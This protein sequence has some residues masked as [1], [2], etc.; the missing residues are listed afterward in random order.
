MTIL[1]KTAGVVAAPAKQTKK[2]A[3]FCCYC[4]AKGLAESVFTSH[5]VKTE[6]GPKGTICC[7]ELL[8]N[9]CGYCHALGH[10]PKFCPKL[11]ARDE[12]R[13]KAA[14]RLPKAISSFAMKQS[15]FPSLPS[16]IAKDSE[17]PAEIAAAHDAWVGNGLIP[18]AIQA[19]GEAFFENIDRTTSIVEEMQGIDAQT[20]EVESFRMRQALQQQNAALKVAFAPQRCFDALENELCRANAQIK[21][22]KAELDAVTECKGDLEQLRSADGSCSDEPPAAARWGDLMHEEDLKASPSNIIVS[23]VQD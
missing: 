23:G 5:F 12:R 21:K 19:E 6:A 16:A 22:L 10:T 7:P 8:K 14:N 4:K 20:K 17:I 13:R 3:K 1:S 9:E 15:E 11:K 2:F 18:T